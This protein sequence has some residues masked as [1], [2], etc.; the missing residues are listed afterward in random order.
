MSEMKKNNKIKDAYFTVP[1]ALRIII[2]V[3]LAIA[4]V[5]SGVIISFMANPEAFRNVFVKAVYPSTYVD[6]ATGEKYYSKFT[7]SPDLTTPEK[8]AESIYFYVYD[9]NGEET[10]VSSDTAVNYNDSEKTL[11]EAFLYTGIEK[12]VG[13]GTTLRKAVPIVIAVLAVAFVAIV[14]YIWFILWCKAEDRRKEREHKNN[15][16]RRKKK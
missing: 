10:E 1:K 14:I 7:D 13:V 12:L 6:A 3:F 11:S 15:N 2:I 16:N 5:I 9:D 8:A 4:V